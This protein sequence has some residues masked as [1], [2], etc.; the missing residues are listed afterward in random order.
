MVPIMATLKA[1]IVGVVG[2]IMLAWNG[3]HNL[4][5]AEET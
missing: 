3:A 1:P 4:T 2:V 5:A